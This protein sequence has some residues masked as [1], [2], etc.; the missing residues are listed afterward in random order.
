MSE[1]EIPTQKFTGYWIPIEL[2]H[3]GLNMQEQWL[4]AMIDSLDSGDP[5]YC[6]A[7]NAYLAEKLQLSESRI[8]FYITKLKRMNLIQEVGYDGRRRRLKSLKH[9]WYLPSNKELCVKARSLSTRKHVVRVREN[10]KHI[11]KDIEKIKEVVCSEPPPVAPVAVKNLQRKATT[12][13]PDGHDV[14]VSLEGVFSA[15]VMEKE[16]WDL[17][18]IEEAWQILCDYKGP[19]RD[20]FAFIKGTIQKLRNNKKHAIITKKTQK[21]NSCNQQKNSVKSISETPKESSTEKGTLEPVLP[22]FAS[23]WSINKSS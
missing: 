23:R 9:N 19:I 12:K 5:G 2:T 18:E 21:K 15:A 11:Q 20:W 17:P 16:N 10:T 8:S 4:L 1:N 3:L 13:H 7:S 6:F 14:E 22:A